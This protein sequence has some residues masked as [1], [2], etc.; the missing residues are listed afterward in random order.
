MELAAVASL[1][2]LA[3]TKLNRDLS[4]PF[5]LLNLMCIAMAAFDFSPFTLPLPELQALVDTL[6]H[7]YEGN[8][9]KACSEMQHLPQFAMQLK[10]FL[11]QSLQKIHINC[12]RNV[13]LFRLN[14]FH[15]GH[16]AFSQL[17]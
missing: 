16:I 1:R 7:L 17:V 4:T 10:V 3:V 8:N 6:A 13:L 15:L 11:L 9:L 2:E 5:I 12:S 14:A